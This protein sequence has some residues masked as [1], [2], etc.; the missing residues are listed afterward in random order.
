MAAGH[1]AEKMTKALKMVKALMPPRS[2]ACRLT[3]PPLSK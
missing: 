3:S 2:E 1:V